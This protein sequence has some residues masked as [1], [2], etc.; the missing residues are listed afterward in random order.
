MSEAK[1]RSTRETVIVPPLELNSNL[2]IIDEL[3]DL[4]MFLQRH[5]FI[6]LGEQASERKLSV[7]QYNLLTFLSFHEALNMSTLAQL[8]GHTTPAT[9]GLV[10]RLHKAGLVER[11]TSEIDRLLR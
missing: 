4:T 7:P 9:T 8:M 5:L 11:T 1:S 6:S 3:A 10:D 2:S